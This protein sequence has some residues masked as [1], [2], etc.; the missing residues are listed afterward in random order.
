MVSDSEKDTLVE[1]KRRG[2]YPRFR[3]ILDCQKGR[4]RTRGEDR[5]KKFRNK[6]C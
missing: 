6:G 2:S 4:M 5:Y 1:G 3:K